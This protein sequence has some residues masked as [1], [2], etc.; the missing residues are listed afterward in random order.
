[1]VIL[2]S[3]FPIDRDHRE[4]PVTTDYGYCN[5]PASGNE[6]ISAEINHKDSINIC[7]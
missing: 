5:I 7:K 1:M 2:K 3:E 6:I 4:I